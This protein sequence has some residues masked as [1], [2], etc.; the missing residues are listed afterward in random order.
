MSDK[1]KNTIENSWP[2]TVRLD[3]IEKSEWYESPSVYQYGFYDGYQSG[4]KEALQN[5]MSIENVQKMAIELAEFALGGYYDK[6]AGIKF[7]AEWRKNND[8]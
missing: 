2:D 7:I 1:M 8:C 3:M 6:T 4:K 5:S